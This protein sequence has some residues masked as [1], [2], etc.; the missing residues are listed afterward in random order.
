MLGQGFRAVTPFYK[1]FVSVMKNLR[2]SPKTNDPS[3]PIW[4]A[5]CYIRIAPSERHAV[6]SGKTYHQGCFTKLHG[7]DRSGRN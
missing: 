7:S 4:C 1:G 3:R 5:H 6:K 2:Q